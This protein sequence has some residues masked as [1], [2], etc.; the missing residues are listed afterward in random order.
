M[1][2]DLIAG[3]GARGEVV[4]EL[5]DLLAEEGHLAAIEPKVLYLEAEADLELRRRVADRL[6]DGSTM[7]MA[8][9]RDLLGT[10]RK[11][12]VPIGEYL[13]RIGLTIRDGDLRRLGTLPESE[14][15]HERA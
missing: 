10:S 3:A 8:N 7:S 5:L 14:E 2:S 4:P 6:G 15:D 13:D 12:A 1:A 9:L 11:Y